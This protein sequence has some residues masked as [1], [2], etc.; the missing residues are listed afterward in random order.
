MGFSFQD[1]IITQVDSDVDRL[2]AS[3]R[4]RLEA[5]AKDADFAQHIIDVPFPSE[6][7]RAID[8]K[9]WSNVS[10]AFWQSRDWFFALEKIVP[11]LLLELMKRQPKNQPSL[12]KAMKFWT[13]PFR[14]NYKG[15]AVET[16]ITRRR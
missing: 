11:V 3:F 7:Y 14:F 8:W 9:R 10:S 2:L 12:E 5:F 16:A 6:E 13:K 15:N 4:E 1:D